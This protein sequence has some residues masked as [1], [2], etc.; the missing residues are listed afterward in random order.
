[1]KGLLVAEEATS[2]EQVIGYRFQRPEW[3][4][5]ALTHRSHSE[6]S[7]GKLSS[8]EQMEFLGDAILGFLVSEALLQKFPEAREGALSK[9]RA[10]LVSAA[11]LHDV[12]EQVELGRFLRLG[13][14]EERSGGRS[15]KA[16][17]VDAL[18]ALVAALY[19]DGGLTA[20]RE[21]VERWILAPV[22]WEQVPTTDFKSEL[23]ELLQERRAPP[24]RY[25]VTREQG[26]EHQK[27]FTVE[28]RVG[29]E[30]IAF[31]EGSTKKA[32]EQAAA[33]IALSR[34]EEISFEPGV[35]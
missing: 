15:K 21:F 26:P 22:D 4:G 7:A 6:E 30:S 5:Q 35:R 16:L 28:L 20:A 3:L 34:F 8:N 11:H 31:A 12:A 18:E 32:A 13:R 9:L 33:Q 1:M 24:P 2:L 10:R 19:C 17:L 23:Q 25:L 29:G 27:T 14:G